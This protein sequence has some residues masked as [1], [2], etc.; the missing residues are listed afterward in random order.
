MLTYLQSL[1]Y[2]AEAN[3][4]GPWQLDYVIALTKAIDA[5]GQSCPRTPCA[6]SS[7]GGAYST[8]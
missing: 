8:V 2:A 3:D 7:A 5:L 1:L 6:K 4:M